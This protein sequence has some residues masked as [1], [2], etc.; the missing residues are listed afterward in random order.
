MA[1]KFISYNGRIVGDNLSLKLLGQDVGPGPPPPPFSDTTS[2]EFDGTDDKLESS[3]SFTC[4]DGETWT[5]ISFWLK[6]PNV[7]LTN[8]NIIKINNL[9]S[10]Y[11]FL[12]FIRT[13]G[14]VDVSTGTGSSFTRTNTGA[15]TSNTW[16]HVFVRLDGTLNRYSALR[17]FV[18]GVNNLSGSNYFGGGFKTNSGTMLLAT[19]GSTA[20]S[21]CYINELAFYTSGDDT[22]PNEIYNSGVANDLNNNTYVPIGWYRSENATWNGSQWT[23]TD[24]KSTCVSLTSSNMVEANRVNDVPDLFSNKSFE[25]DGTDDYIEIPDA[26]NLSFGN[27]VNDSPFSVSVWTKLNSQASSKGIFSKFN[28]SN[29]N[30]EYG[31]VLTNADQL[32]FRVFDISSLN[33]RGRITSAITSNF[34][35]WVNIVCTY[36]GVGGTNADQGIKIYLNGVRID[37]ANSSLNNY[38]A[39]HNLNTPFNIGNQSNGYVQGD[40]DEVA[41]FNSELSQTDVNDIFNNG[42]PTS[43]ES[44]SPISHWRMG[45]DATW[46]GTN[47]TLNDNGSGGNN[48][49]SQN[50]VLASRTSDV[51]LFN[52]KSILFDGI[53]DIVSLSSRTQ[54]FTDFSVSAWFIAVSGGSYKAIFGNTTAVGGYLFAIVNASGAIYFYDNGWRQ[55]SGTVTDGNW[56][57]LIVTYDSSANELKS[58]V[59]NSLYTTYTPNASAFP[60]NSHSFNQIGGRTSVG[61]WNG[62]LDELA[63]WDSVLDSTQVS[64]IYN[65]G[66]PNDLSSTNPIHWWRMGDYD[67]YPTLIDRGSGSNNGTMINMSSGSIVND[68]P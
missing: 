46:N 51:P 40:I 39:M 68:V 49:T 26:D 20:Y 57:H 67:S 2:F 24:E 18:D 1:R 41:V 12:C 35:N 29:G 17:V 36:N 54:N 22:L 27:S 30:A 56:H 37:N 21:N 34:G 10:G 58:Y 47:W 5:G 53:D 45:E 14:V 6:I 31:L 50:M 61:R 8:E 15:I 13:N 55:L 3:S 32:I 11:S 42:V 63:V 4:L 48:G 38:V 16:H 44:F 65:G 66:I 9:V 33:R 60:S 19:N 59:D 23:M 64:N 7:T 62:N 43:L 52:T 25:F 28:R